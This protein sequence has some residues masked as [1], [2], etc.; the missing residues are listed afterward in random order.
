M[1]FT[2]HYLYVVNCDCFFPPEP[3]VFPG[4][5]LH[6][7]FI[8]VAGYTLPCTRTVSLTVCERLMS[9]FSLAGRL[10]CL[11]FPLSSWHLSL[12]SSWGLT[13]NVSAG[14][15]A[16][17]WRPCLFFFFLGFLS[18]FSY[19]YPPIALWEKMWRKR[20]FW[21]WEYHYS[22]LTLIVCQ[23]LEI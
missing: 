8:C 22:I 9:V 14:A 7:T 21:V 23:G 3:F 19:A 20:L 18:H 16:V 4:L 10:H 13:S 12:S 17:L 2:D 6:L 1:L 15:S 11:L 5:I